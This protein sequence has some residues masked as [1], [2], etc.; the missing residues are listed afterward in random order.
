VVL[1]VAFAALLFFGEPPKQCPNWHLPG[2]RSSSL[3]VPFY[4]FMGPIL[5]ALLLMVARWERLVRKAIEMDYPT[6]TSVRYR[7]LII[8]LMGCSVSQFPWIVLASN[9][10]H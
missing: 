3:W 10:L 5:M 1:A 2:A 9:C 4:L 6:M 7:L 8:V